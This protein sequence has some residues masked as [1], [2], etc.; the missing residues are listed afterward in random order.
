[1]SWRPVGRLRHVRQL[2]RPQKVPEYSQIS[3]RHGEVG[4]VL[5]RSGATC[6]RIEPIHSSRELN[7]L[8]YRVAQGAYLRRD[9]LGQA[10]PMGPQD[11]SAAHHCLE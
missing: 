3:L 6:G 5:F 2:G 8:L 11:R 1:V 10:P 4:K 9:D 7:Q